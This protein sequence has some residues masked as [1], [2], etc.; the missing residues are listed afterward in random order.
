MAVG[1][2]T[3]ARLGTRRA[4]TRPPLR[5]GN[6]RPSSAGVR[7][8]SRAAGT[9]TP[10]RCVAGTVAHPHF[11]RVLRERAAHAQPIA[12]G[13]TRHARAIYRQARLAYHVQCMEWNARIGAMHGIGWRSVL[14]AALLQFLMRIPGDVQSHD[15]VP[16]GLMR[17]AMRGT[18]PNAIIDRRSK[19][20]FTHLANAS[21]DHDF[22]AI[23]EIRTDGA[24]RAV[25]I[26]RRPSALAAAGPVARGDSAI[27]RHRADDA[28]RES[29]RRRAVPQAIFRCGL[30]RFDNRR[31]GDGG[32]LNANRLDAP[33][34][35]PVVHHLY[36]IRVRTPWAVSGV[37]SQ[38]GDFWDVEFVEGD[39]AL[40]AQAAAQVPPHQAGWWAQYAAL[41]DGSSYRRWT[42]L[43]EFLVTPDARRIHARTLSRDAHDEALLAYLLVDALSFSMVRLGRE[44][45]H[46]TAV[47]TDNGVAAFVGD[48]GDGKSTLAAL[49]VR[50]GGRLLTDDMLILSD[51]DDGFTAQPGPPRIKLYRDVATRI[52]GAGCHG[53]PMNAVTEKLIIALDDRQVARA[54]ARL[55][56]LYL[57][58]DEHAGDAPARPVIGP[59]SCRPLKRCRA[60]CR[61]GGT[62]P[63]RAPAGSARQFGPRPRLV[64]RVP[65]KTLSYPG[66]PDDMWPVRDAVL[67]DLARAGGGSGYGRRSARRRP[68]GRGCAMGRVR[69]DRRRSDRRVRGAR[70]FGPR[71]SAA[72][73]ATDADDSPDDAR[74]A[75]A[76]VAR[77]AEAAELLRGR[78]IALVLD[79]LASAG[80]HA[81]L[82]K[83]AALAYTVYNFRPAPDRAPIPISSSG[84]NRSRRRGA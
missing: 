54:P 50:G 18:V 24:V 46:A 25:W 6:R 4:T 49:F 11:Q 73:R 35:T 23:R 69:V 28:H 37:A 1:A 20:E 10:G 22:A 48:S 44:P 82:L 65:I 77:E 14:D 33:P 72:L 19:G 68:Q 9:W 29:L 15:G 70:D 21:I 34:A 71:L 59:A 64:A 62:L 7:D 75:L 12:I 31:A 26:R 63:I 56:A 76:G 81:I 2:A 83:G 5:P 58:H 43:F 53:V 42:N 40:L 30:R 36:G 32:M 52:F 3:R 57:I 84:A 51:E 66:Q 41:P 79:A 80:V 78:E 39:R 61:D 8:A 38:R 45:L 55:S 60:A 47:Q 67:D 13:G 17:A 74:A 16:R 27:E